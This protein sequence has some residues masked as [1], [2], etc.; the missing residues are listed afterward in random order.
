MF[1]FV[2]RWREEARSLLGWALGAGLVSFAGVLFAAIF[3]DLEETAR[4]LGE[5]LAK[6]PAPLRGLF[7]GEAVIAKAPTRLVLGTAFNAIIPAL[8]LVY[9]CLAA[10][11]IYTREAGRGNLEFLF[12]LPVDRFHLVLGRVLVFLV[13]L[14]STDSTKVLL[15]SLALFFGLFVLNISQ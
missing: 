6:A 12:S 4:L 11:G 15:V 14:A 10:A 1:L 5:W 9:V 8:V 2:H 7:G 13:G 3:L